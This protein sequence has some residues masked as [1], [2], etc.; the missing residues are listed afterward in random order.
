MA[1]VPLT[2]PEVYMAHSVEEARSIVTLDEW[3]KINRVK[4]SLGYDLSRSDDIPGMFRVGRQIRVDLV[5]VL[6]CASS[7][8][9]FC[10]FSSLDS[11]W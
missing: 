5:F 6:G 2:Q 10:R 1:V 11:L 3:C 9:C 8:F 4:K 7:P